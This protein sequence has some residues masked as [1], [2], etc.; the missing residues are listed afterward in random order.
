MRETKIFHTSSNII[1][2][3]Q[4]LVR[5]A[6]ANI[7]AQLESAPELGFW[8]GEDASLHLVLGEAFVKFAQCAGF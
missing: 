4:F 5:I 7:A 2:R 6:R 1:L 8:R 3:E